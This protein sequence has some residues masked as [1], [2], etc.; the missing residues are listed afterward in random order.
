MSAQSK[1]CRQP[2]A[3]AFQG[4]SFT[5]RR[6]FTPQPFPGYKLCDI[7]APCPQIKKAA[8]K[9]PFQKTYRKFRQLLLSKSRSRQLIAQFTSPLGNKEH[10]TTDQS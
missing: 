7:R 5:A 1:V 3:C 10:S 9:R 4:E 2:C 6:V 8:R